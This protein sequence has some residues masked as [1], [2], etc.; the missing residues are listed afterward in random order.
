MRPLIIPVPAAARSTEN[1]S[2]AYHSQAGTVECRPLLHITPLNC[3]LPMKWFFP[4]SLRLR[5]CMP[6]QLQHCYHCTSLSGG[7]TCQALAHTCRCPGYRFRL[8]SCTL[9][10]LLY[11]DLVASGT[12]L[13]PSPTCSFRYSLFSELCRQGRLLTRPH[14][15]PHS[16]PCRMPH[17]LRL[18]RCRMTFG[19]QQ[20][21]KPRR[22]CR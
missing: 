8:R 14:Q 21:L 9:L 22:Q 19:I 16:V 13:A 4:L 1:S 12:G 6:A 10:D 5:W 18:F 11:K 20:E 3:T 15:S 7:C 2:R 17:F